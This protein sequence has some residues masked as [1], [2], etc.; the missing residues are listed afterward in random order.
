LWVGYQQFL[1]T[2]LRHL[3][4]IK[5]NQ[6]ITPPLYVMRVIDI[7]L[8]SI[9]NMH[10]M[11]EFVH[12]IDSEYYISVTLQIVMDLG[13]CFNLQDCSLLSMLQNISHFK[14]EI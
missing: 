2:S 6:I 12:L 7:R 1:A 8:S 13:S 10:W 5:S 11:S 3:N 14:Y 9:H 4:Q